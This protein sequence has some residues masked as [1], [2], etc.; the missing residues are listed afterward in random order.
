M[1]NSDPLSWL[2]WALFLAGAPLLA[3]V[4]NKLKARLSGRFGPS[5]FQPY[6]ELLRLARKEAF[7]WI[8]RDPALE[9][10]KSQPVKRALAKRFADAIRLIEVG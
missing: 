9:R 7:E 1:V 6:Y 2:T 8:K 4:V 5:V 3:G 10:P